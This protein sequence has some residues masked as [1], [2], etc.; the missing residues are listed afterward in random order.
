MIK[1]EV[2]AHCQGV[3]RV[4]ILAHGLHPVVC[5]DEAALLSPLASC[6]HLRVLWVEV[7][8]HLA[9]EVS[10]QKPIVLVRAVADVGVCLLAVEEAPLNPVRCANG[11]ERHVYLELPPVR[12]LAAQA[13]VDD[14][15]V[16]R[17][18]RRGLLNPH[19]HDLSLL[20]VD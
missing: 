12:Q 9:H 17:H 20:G 4:E 1:A 18:E 3:V 15:E 7:A 14:V 5:Q 10:V 11:I 13:V 6:V 19:E 2:V 8:V 16:V